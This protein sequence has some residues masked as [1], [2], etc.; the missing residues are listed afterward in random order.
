[1]PTRN[2]MRRSR[3]VE[4]GERLAFDLLLYTGQ[5]VGDVAALR[6]S[7]QRDSAIHLRPEKTGDELRCT[8]I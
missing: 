5:R 8:I 6:R 4:D 1:M 2:S 7:D 3:G